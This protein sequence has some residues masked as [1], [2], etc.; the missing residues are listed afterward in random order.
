M[1]NITIDYNGIYIFCNDSRLDNSKSSV[2]SGDFDTN[3]FYKNVHHFIHHKRSE[4]KLL[5]FLVCII[6]LKLVFDVLFEIHFH[7]IKYLV[8]LLYIFYTLFTAKRRKLYEM[9]NIII[10]IIIFLLRFK[11]CISKILQARGY[12]IG[13]TNKTFTYC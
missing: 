2:K 5:R 6:S 3:S 7:I 11:K 8:S 4:E 9:I 12:Y 1:T 13:M 10:I